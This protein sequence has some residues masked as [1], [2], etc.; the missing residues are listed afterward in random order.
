MLLIY[1]ACFYIFFQAVMSQAQSKMANW[2]EKAL[3]FTSVIPA[4][5]AVMQECLRI[6]EHLKIRLRAVAKL[7][8]PI[9]KQRHVRAIYEGQKLYPYVL[10]H[11]ISITITSK[12]DTLQTLVSHMNQRRR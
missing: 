3:S 7:Q 1:S 8:S 10:Y 9:L 2:K 12:H 11:Q 5:D 4:Q 6:L